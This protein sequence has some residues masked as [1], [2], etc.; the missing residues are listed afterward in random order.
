MKIENS[1]EPSHFESLYPPDSRFSEI[2]KILSYIKSGNSVQV[3]SLIGVGRSNV[4][5]I[6]AYNHAV[7]TLHLGENQ[8]WFHFVMMNFAEIKKRPLQDSI[9]YMFIEILESLSERKMNEEHTHVKK[10]F[11]ES[12]K[13]RDELVIF[14]G[15]KKTIDYLCLEKEFTVILLFDRFE[16]YVGVLE[17]SFFDNLRVLRDRAKYRFSCIFPLSRPLEETVGPQIISSFYEFLVGNL[18]YLTLGDEKIREFRLSYLKKTSGKNVDKKVLE[19]ISNLTG[20][21]GKL[22]LVSIEVCLTNS[23]TAQQ[24]TNNKLSHFLLSNTRVK[25]VILEIWESLSPYEQNILAASSQPFELSQGKRLASSSEGI[26]H[27]E[28]VGLIKN[29]KTTVPLLEAYAKTE[30]K[31]IKDQIVYD[32]GAKEIRR[33]QTVLSEGL[34]S[35][36]FKL[37]RFMAENPEKILE[38]DDV[39]NAVWG[40]LSSTAGVSE[41]ALDQLI[42]RVRKKIEENPNSPIHIQTVKGRGFKFTP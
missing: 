10:L 8:K 1:L 16:E 38:R 11:D 37:L 33:G 41:Q 19:E 12:L 3:I 40:E 2:E 34:T 35:S 5:R 21:L 29:N 4:L 6:L 7:R 9:K 36:E 28:K 20:G 42:F 18:V 39:I 14:Q 32:A 31:N 30:G 17:P 23:T 27:L 22:W 25:S 26:L 24:T 13:S 15:L